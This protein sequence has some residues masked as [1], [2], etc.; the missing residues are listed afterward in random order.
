[1]DDGKVRLV[2]PP[3]RG[4]TPAIELCQESFF[5]FMHPTFKVRDFRSY[6]RKL[7]FLDKWDVDILTAKFF[8]GESN[9]SISNMFGYLSEKSVRV[10]LKSLFKLFKERLKETK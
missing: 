9:A 6:L 10:R 7:G 8:Y 5:S 4:Q 3:L 1:M 2:Y